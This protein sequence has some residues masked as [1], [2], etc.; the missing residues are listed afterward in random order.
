MGKIV[1][2]VLWKLRKA[3][4]EEAL[5]QAKASIAALKNVPGPETMQ[6]GPPLMDARAK[7]YDWG[8]YSVFSSKAALQE[9]AVSEAHVN[10]VKNNVG[11]NVEEVLAYD[12]ELEA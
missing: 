6:L 9:Y 10:V 7:G 5:V 8:L 1:H 12:F 4:N 11:P 3:A 2:I